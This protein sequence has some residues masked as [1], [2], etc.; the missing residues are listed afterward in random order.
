MEQAGWFLIDEMRDD[1]VVRYEERQADDHSPWRLRRVED[2]AWI[3]R[4]DGEGDG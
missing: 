4:A 2:S 1:L 3:R